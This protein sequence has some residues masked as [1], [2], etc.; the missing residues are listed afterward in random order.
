MD[1]Q[2]NSY[3]KKTTTTTTTTLS[4]TTVTAHPEKLMDLCRMAKKQN[5]ESGRNK[6][7]SK[8]INDEEKN[9]LISVEDEIYNLA[10]RP[11][12]QS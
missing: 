4:L 11:A 7:I 9:D 8:T 2:I 1:N 12:K 3:E 6:Q 5:T 10:F